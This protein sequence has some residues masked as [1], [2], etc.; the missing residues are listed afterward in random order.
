M[1]TGKAVRASLDNDGK[2]SLADMPNFLPVIPYVAPAFEHI[3]EVPAQFSD[4]DET[5][6]E[7]LK[8]LIVKAVGEITDHEK[9]IVQ[10]NESLAWIHQTYKLVNAFKA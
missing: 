7:E 10:I 3:T 8:G 5:E 1:H 4:I 9:L 2:L 6:A